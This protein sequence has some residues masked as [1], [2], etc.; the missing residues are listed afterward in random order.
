MA[1]SSQIDFRNQAG[2]LVE[3][4]LVHLVAVFRLQVPRIHFRDHRLLGKTIGFPNRAHGHQ[5]RLG[6]GQLLPGIE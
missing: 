5:R 3:Q 2:V 1:P 6:I 4:F